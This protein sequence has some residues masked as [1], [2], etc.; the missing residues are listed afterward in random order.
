MEKWKKFSRGLKEIK[1][2]H[3]KN[4]N[5]HKENFEKLN[6]LMN[7]ETKKNQT[8]SNLP[9]FLETPAPDSSFNLLQKIQD[10]YFD[11]IVKLDGDDFN[12]SQYFPNNA[13]NISIYVEETTTQSFCTHRKLKISF[14]ATITKTIDY[15]AY[16]K[17]S[18]KLDIPELLCFVSFVLEVQK[19]RAEDS[20]S[21]VQK[22]RSKDHK[23]KIAVTCEAEKT[24]LFTLYVALDAIIEEIHEKGFFDLYGFIKK[25]IEFQPL[26]LKNFDQYMFLI[27]SAS[28][29]LTFKFPPPPPPT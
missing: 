14:S 26:E 25:K 9:Y 10:G 1:Y 17:P 2:S 27:E 11:T 24:D 16:T 28:W 12:L 4:K 23:N 22:Y 5:E 8:A 20:V 29:Y 15:L 21:E 13:E 3:K 19:C 18:A 6:N 7:T